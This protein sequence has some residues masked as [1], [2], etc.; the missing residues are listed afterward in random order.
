METVFRY[1]NIYDRAIELIASGKVLLSAFRQ[2][3]I[4]LLHLTKPLSDRDLRFLMLS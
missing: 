2:F 4:E 1:A 3:S